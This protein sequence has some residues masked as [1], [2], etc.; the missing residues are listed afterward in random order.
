M[1]VKNIDEVRRT[2]EAFIEARSDLLDAGADACMHQGLYPNM[3]NIWQ[4]I[5]MELYGMQAG[6]K[7]MDLSAGLGQLAEEYVKQANLGVDF[8]G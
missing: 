2:F 1:A 6:E 5:L 7:A 8:D 4:T 3:R